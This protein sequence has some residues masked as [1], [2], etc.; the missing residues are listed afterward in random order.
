MRSPC[1]FIL[2]SPGWSVSALRERCGSVGSV[3]SVGGAVAVVA[4]D[5]LADE[6]RSA[7][8]GRFAA[9]R[10]FAGDGFFA[11][12]VLAPLLALA[13]LL[14]RPPSRWRLVQVNSTGLRRAFR[15]AAGGVWERPSRPSPA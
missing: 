1:S 13:G 14:I 5:R 6:A 15:A 12:D 9:G 11:E 10:L 8:D 3:G 7:A 4:E 2:R